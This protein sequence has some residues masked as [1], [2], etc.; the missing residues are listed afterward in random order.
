M[1]LRSPGRLHGILSDNDGVSQ[2]WCASL[3]DLFSLYDTMRLM[4]EKRDHT[5][6]SHCSFL[7]YERTIRCRKIGAEAIY[8]ARIPGA[9][10]SVYGRVVDVELTVHTGSPNA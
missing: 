2:S 3:R 7:S 6:P 1:A 8:H 4:G 5:L 9:S 10:H